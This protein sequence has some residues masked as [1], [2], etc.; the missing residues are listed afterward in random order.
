MGWEGDGELVMAELVR[1]CYG[2]LAATDRLSLTSLSH[3]FT[4][5]ENHT[6]VVLKMVK[7][8]DKWQIKNILYP[9]D[10]PSQNGD[11]ITILKETQKKRD[12]LMR[13]NPKS[14]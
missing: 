2:K 5:D 10:D 12:E 14:H 11:L 13:E 3:S 6:R 9:A 4:L 1:H 7:I 8:G